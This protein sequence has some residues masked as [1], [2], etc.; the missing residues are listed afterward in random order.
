MGERNAK[1]TEDATEDGLAAGLKLCDRP[2]CGI[3][4]PMFNRFRQ[5]RYYCSDACGALVRREAEL[6]RRVEVK[7]SDGQTSRA[8]AARERGALI[9]R[10]YLDFRQ[11]NTHVWD[12]LVE[13]AGAQVVAGARRLSIKQLFE[14]MRY[15]QSLVTGEDRFKL[16]NDFTSRYARDLMAEHPRFAGRFETR[17]LAGEGA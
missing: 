17:A 5:R 11:A 13:L 4:H 14:V 12:R 15:E 7:L 8:V 1:M 10:R 2:G 3:E 9:E 16:N 6:D